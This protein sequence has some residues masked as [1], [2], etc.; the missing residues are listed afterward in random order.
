MPKS[1]LRALAVDDL[2]NGVAVPNRETWTSFAICTA[3][4]NPLEVVKAPSNLKRYGRKYFGFNGIP[5][6]S[7]E[8]ES[9]NVV[10][11]TCAR[12]P[13]LA[14]SKSTSSLGWP[15][16]PGV[17]DQD[18]EKG[19]A[20][21]PGAGSGILGKAKAAFNKIKDTVSK[22]LDD[23]TTPESSCNARMLDMPYGLFNNDVGKRKAFSIT[24]ARA[25]PI[26]GELSQSVWGF[27][28]HGKS[29]T[30][31]FDSYG[32][33]AADYLYQVPQGK[34]AP[35]DYYL[36][37]SRE[38]PQLC[39]LIG[40][41]LKRVCAENYDPVQCNECEDLGT[42][43]RCQ[44]RGWNDLFKQWSRVPIYPRD[45]LG[46]LHR[47]EWKDVLARPLYASVVFSKESLTKKIKTLPENLITGKGPA[48]KALGISSKLPAARPPKTLFYSVAQPCDRPD[49]SH[50]GAVFL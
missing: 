12:V 38:K 32:P 37:D 18:S 11:A 30:W 3:P 36:C 9:C 46:E 15:C 49:Y 34:G 17:P 6:R 16:E 41:N 10:H 7:D 48:S 22:L 42:H 23:G 44:V 2:V 13:K 43:L 25:K 26:E 21:S 20:A 29:G 47:G 1:G 14:K 28:V 33:K 24:T 8:E 50:V 27:A 40:G 35:S 45:L 5:C 31:A 39:A 4:T 19:T